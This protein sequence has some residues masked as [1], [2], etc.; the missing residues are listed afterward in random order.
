VAPLA[1]VTVPQVPTADCGGACG[2]LVGI[3]CSLGG[4]ASADVG[5]D[6]GGADGCT[7]ALGRV[8]WASGEDALEQAPAADTATAVSVAAT[9]K[10]HRP[11]RLEVLNAIPS[12]CVPGVLE[13]TAPRHRG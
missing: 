12:S 2:C 13:G 10:R 7:E 1:A 9:A 5:E 6:T 8:G 4:G 3:V 11:A